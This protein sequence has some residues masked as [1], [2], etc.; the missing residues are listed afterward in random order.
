RRENGPEAELGLYAAGF[1][2]LVTI[3]GLRETL[4]TTPYTFCTTRCCQFAHLRIRIATLLDGLFSAVTLALLLGLVW[5][6]L[7]CSD[8]RVRFSISPPF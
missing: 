6:D 8:L 3:V 4:I 1:G 5:F 2:V 7:Q